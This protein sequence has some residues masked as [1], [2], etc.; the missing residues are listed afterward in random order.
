MSRSKEEKWLLSV[1]VLLG[2]AILFLGMLFYYLVLIDH[3]INETKVI[4]MDQIERV[5]K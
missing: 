1:N 5:K 2:G 4:L 3:S